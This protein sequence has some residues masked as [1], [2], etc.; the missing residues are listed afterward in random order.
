MNTNIRQCFVPC[1]PPSET[2]KYVYE[3]HTD[4]PIESLK[5]DLG[6][7]KK[8][9]VVC[10]H[11]SRTCTDAP[12]CTGE[13]NHVFDSPRREVVQEH[14]TGRVKSKNKNHI[15][16]SVNIDRHENEK[17]RISWAEELFS[18]WGS[19]KSTDENRKTE[20]SAD[21][22]N[23]NETPTV[24]DKKRSS[25]GSR[26][27]SWDD[28]EVYSPWASTTSLHSKKESSGRTRDSINEDLYPEA[29]LAT[30][31]KDLA[32]LQNYE[33]THP[34]AR[35]MTISEE[36]QLPLSRNSGSIVR[37]S[38]KL[39]TAT[40]RQSQS[41][42]Y[43]SRPSNSSPPQSRS[44]QS[45]PT[46][47]SQSKT[48]PSQSRPPQS[49]PTRLEES[50]PKSLTSE[51]PKSHKNSIL[52]KLKPSFVQELE[53]KQMTLAGHTNIVDPE[54][55]R[56]QVN[57]LVNNNETVSK[58]VGNFDSE[59]RRAPFKVG[60]RMSLTNRFRPGYEKSDVSWNRNPENHE[61]TSET[62]DTVNIEQPS[63][64]SDEEGYELTSRR[65]SLRY[66]K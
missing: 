52:S 47:S 8:Y 20:K 24:F 34:G 29:A 41:S 32:Y 61:K 63:D 1:K 40:Q 30:V 4:S 15:E 37:D 54:I 39:D 19:T 16:N 28:V 25:S 33:N 38:E 9:K 2:H 12:F 57:K 36:Q 11:S 51:S 5:F 42:S 21:Q 22:K 3:V 56:N 55:K 65:F 27:M 14:G 45:R 17:P 44:S 59:E 64:V 10:M 66:S 7:G 31:E 43:K 23:K 46:Q 48:R 62:E 60:D 26:R 58:A 18:P 6:S 49:S 35:K 53:Q 13:T 50:Q